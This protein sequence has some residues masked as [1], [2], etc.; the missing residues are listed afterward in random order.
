MEIFF[1]LVII[2]ALINSGCKA[3]KNLLEENVNSTGNK[4]QIEDTVLK[5]LQ[6][7]S[8]LVIAF[9]T[10]NY[11]WVKSMDYSIITKN[12]GEWKGYKYHLNLMNG[13]AGSPT[14]LNTLVVDKTACE[15]IAN[16]ITDNKAWSIKGDNG[17]SFCSDGNKNCNINDAANSRL[18]IITK[19]AYIDPSYYA[20]DFY[21]TCCPEPQRG[22][23]LSITKKNCGSIRNCC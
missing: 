20:P 19:S 14:T 13:N 9:A 10:E 3:Q 5:K 21:E 1:K 22:L 7:E 8:D 12:N 4:Q 2:M 18:W 16:F 11:A 23:F 6:A 17:K 15:A